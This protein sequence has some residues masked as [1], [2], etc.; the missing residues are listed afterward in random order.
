MDHT[1]TILTATITINSSVESSLVMVVIGFPVV[2]F[3]N[4]DV[5]SGVVGDGAPGG[6]IV[7]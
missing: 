6:L 3:G 4:G 2:E 1:C 7:C 5:K